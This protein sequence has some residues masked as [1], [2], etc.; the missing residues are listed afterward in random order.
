MAGIL[1]THTR[2]ACLGRL[3]LTREARRGPRKLKKAARAHGLAFST[4]ELTRHT[5]VHIGGTSKTIGRHNEVDDVTAGKF[6]DQFADEFG[7]KGWWR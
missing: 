4:T 6:F 5:A 3:D 2:R 7:G 1:S